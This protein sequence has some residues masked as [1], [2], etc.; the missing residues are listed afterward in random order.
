[1]NVFQHRADKQD[2]ESVRDI[3]QLFLEAVL[4]PGRGADDWDC[5]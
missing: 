1:M 3:W 2:K 5:D 4:E